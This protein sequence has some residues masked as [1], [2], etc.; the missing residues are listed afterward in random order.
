LLRKRRN[1]AKDQKTDEGGKVL[2]YHGGHRFSFPGKAPG[3][4]VP[5]SV[6]WWFQNVEMLSRT[7]SR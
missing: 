2:L 5:R 1:K 4:A 7:I 3:A 6:R